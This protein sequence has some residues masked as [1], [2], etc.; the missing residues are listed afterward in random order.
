MS[1]FLQDVVI[2]KLNGYYLIL[3]ANDRKTAALF[4]YCI[5]QTAVYFMVFL[6]LIPPRIR[7][8]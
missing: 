3:C 2:N 7:R 5:N 8:R 4:M 1:N 6:R